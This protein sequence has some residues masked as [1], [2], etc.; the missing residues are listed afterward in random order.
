[1]GISVIGAAAS[2]GG[3]GGSSDFVINTGDYSSDTAELSTEF[4][5]G[6]YSITASPT[7]STLD[8]Y[9]VASDGSFAGYTNTGSI[10]A[11]IPFDK[12][13]VL[14]STSSTVLSFIFNG[15]SQTAT[16]KGQLGGAG[17]VIGSCYKLTS[18]CG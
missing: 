9:L 1:M 2:S 8:I 18:F 15:E 13:V 17:A 6:A 11:T 14:G 7:D 12:V 3:G 4:A 16:T 5:A 10:T